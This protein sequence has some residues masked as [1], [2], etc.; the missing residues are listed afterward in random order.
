M[1]STTPPPDLPVWGPPADPLIAQYPSPAR[2]IE[3]RRRQRQHVAHR[4]RRIAGVA[5]LASSAA[6]V[7]YMATATAEHSS[8]TPAVAT[9][10]TIAAA[11]PSI[12]V[13]QPTAATAQPTTT[14]APV[15]TVATPVVVAATPAVQTPAVQTQT[16]RTR[17]G[18][19]QPNSSSHSS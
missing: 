12:A 16:G 18:Q 4:G 6:I 17:Q 1:E 9:T 15:T 19:G 13:T 11:T 14:A 3:P 10:P 8:S 2:H 5:A 7:G